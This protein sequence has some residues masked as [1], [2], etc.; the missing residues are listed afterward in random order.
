MRSANA[1]AG[2]PNGFARKKIAGMQH[3]YSG[4]LFPAFRC[5]GSNHHSIDFERMKLRC[6]AGRGKTFLPRPAS[7]FNLRSASASE[8]WRA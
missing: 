4:N 5:S 2:T 7:A 1:M 6:D 8:Q 3:R